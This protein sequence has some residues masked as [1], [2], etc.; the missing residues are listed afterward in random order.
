MADAGGPAGRTLRGGCPVI[1]RIIVPAFGRV[2]TNNRDGS[3]VRFANL[4]TQWQRA[5]HEVVIVAP[6]REIPVLRSQGVTAE[7]I[8]VPEW[9]RS[10][11]DTTWNVV[12]VYLE[13]LWRT[14]WL[15]Y[16]RSFD[17][18]YAPSDFLV[19]LL[20]AVRM[21]QRGV[22][23]KLVV[24]M[25][26]VA[27]PPGKEYRSMFAPG[28]R[29]APRR[30]RTTLYYLTQQFALRLMRRYADKVL[31]LN[32]IDCAVVSRVLGPDRVS[33]VSMGVDRLTYA[34]PEMTA[35]K[36]YDAVFVGRLH[37]QKGVEDLPRIWERVIAIAPAATLAVIGGGDSK[38]QDAL[39][40]ELERRGLQAC[41]DVLGFRT[42]AAKMSVLKS[43]K[44][45]IMP[46]Y[47]ES[48]GMV[49]CEALAA[50]LPVVAY[51]LPIYRE[52]F[53]GGVVTVP[54]GEPE[55]FAVECARLIGD[56][57]ARHALASAGEAVAAA[58]DW[59]CVSRAELRLMEQVLAS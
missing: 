51:D 7:V 57:A 30:F 9:L 4:C 23:R 45:F 1:V 32:S 16:D 38:H 22:A 37:P 58:Y 27:P 12:A 15:R 56:T 44:L 19:D 49:I 6:E 33:I 53:S 5:G 21:K 10:E 43:A 42:G 59:E 11:R 50:G 8:E 34:Q 24:C 31:V 54:I 26:L 47:Y 55:T 18:A 3:E 17:V 40:A 2:N 13:R 35:G 14:T 39:V 52:L 48:W 25:F 20:P 29:P 36:R 28:A 41:V 46:S